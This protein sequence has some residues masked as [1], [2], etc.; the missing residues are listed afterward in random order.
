MA[1]ALRWF[2]CGRGSGNQP[3]IAL[4]WRSLF[5]GRG[6]ENQPPIDLALLWFFCGRGSENQPPIALRFAAGTSPEGEGLVFT[7]ESFWCAGGVEVFGLAKQE[8]RLAPAKQ[9]RF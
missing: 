9:E 3:P 1:L 8:R 6:S 2:V 4:A 7:S 5:C